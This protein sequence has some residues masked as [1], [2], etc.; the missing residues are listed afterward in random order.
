VLLPA[1]FFPYDPKR[2]S[3]QSYSND[4]HGDVE[5]EELGPRDIN[6]PVI[7]KSPNQ[8]QQNSIL[9]ANVNPAVDHVS[10]IAQFA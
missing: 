7:Q 3:E 4:A 9:H 8:D 2:H 5:C 10:R 1:Q 6:S